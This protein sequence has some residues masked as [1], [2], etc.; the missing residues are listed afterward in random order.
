MPVEVAHTVTGPG[1][2]PV[3]VLSS[4]LGATR[5]MWDAQ[6]GALSDRFRVVAYDHRGHGESPVPA[7]PYAIE[8][9]ARD[10]VALLDR[11]G[12]ERAHF[13]GLSLGGMVGMWLGA[14]APERVD[15]LVLLCT[16]A[17]LGPP[18][19]WADRAAQVR[20][21]GTGTIAEAVVSRW[22]TE[23][24]AAAHPDVVAGLRAMVASIPAEGYASCCAAIEHMDLEPVLD[25]ITA[26]T[27]VVGG[28]QDPATPP[29]HQERIAAA[30]AGARL[31]ILSP[32]A[33]VAAVE[34]ADAVSA[35]IG[36]HLAR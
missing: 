30:I 1:D 13:A 4:S 11:L 33:H 35:L 9:V 36:E 19:M 7:G 32:A 3:L 29:E 17:K 12:V 14:H 24:Y 26:P 6:V 27:L 16:S 20:T 23:P 22:V 10:A 25:R 21:G 18:E 8:D 2:A 31:E 34:R 28:E 15:R 5:A